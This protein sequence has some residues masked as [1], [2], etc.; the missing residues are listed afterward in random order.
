MESSPEVVVQLWGNSRN[1]DGL[2]GTVQLA[3]WDNVFANVGMVFCEEEVAGGY[4][5]E[6]LHGSGHAI[7]LVSESIMVKFD[8]QC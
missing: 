6:E 4:R 7:A 8:G 5:L 3:I 1:L 2:V